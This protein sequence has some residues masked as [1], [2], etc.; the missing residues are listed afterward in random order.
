MCGFVVQVA[1]IFFSIASSHG[2]A[3]MHTHSHSRLICQYIGHDSGGTD[4]TK[5][6]TRHYRVVLDTVFTIFPTAPAAIILEEDLLV[7]SDFY[8]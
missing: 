8:R 7:A 5:R 2:L 6:I 4:V 1:L 3:H